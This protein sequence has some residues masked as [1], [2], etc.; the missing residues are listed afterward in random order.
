MKDEHLHFWNR[1]IA[2]AEGLEAAPSKMSRRSLFKLA[3]GLGAGLV[4]GSYLPVRA[5]D[6][7]V[8]FAPN[9][10]IIV[11]PENTVTVIVKH[12]DKGQGAA[13]GL[14]TLVAEEMDAAWSQIQTE[15][16]PSDA[17]RYKNLAFGVQGVGGS[18]GLANSFMQYRQAGAAARQML[19]AAAARMWAVSPADLKVSNG[20]IM[21]GNDK[22]TFGAM[23]NRAGQEEMPAKPAVKTPDKFVYIGRSFPRVDSRAKCTG[24]AKFTLDLAFPDMLIATMLRPPRFGATLIAFDALEAR[25]IAGVKDVVAVDRGIA[26]VADSTWTALKAREAVKAEWNLDAAET[27][28]TSDMHNDYSLLL[29]MPGTPARVDGDVEKA[30]TE[31]SST[32]EA[33][34]EFPYLAHAPMEPMNA[35]VQFDGKRVDVWTGSQ[36]QTIDQGVAAGVFGVKPENVAIHT[37]WAGGSFG[38]RAAADSHYVAE[39]CQIVKALKTPLPVKLVWTRDDDI[40]G[41]YFRPFYM[42]KIKAALDRDGNVS[43]WK[44]RIV[45]QSILEG[46]LFAALMIKNGVD[47]TSVEG[48]KN[49]PYAIPNF[50]LDLHAPKSKVPVLWWRSVG[51]T[52]T[53]HATEHMIDILAREAGKDP[54]EFRLAM[55]KDKPRHSG[56]LKLAA[57]KAGWG[58]PLAP[59]VHRGVGVH[60]SF[61]SYVA[62]VVEV[63]VKED[64]TF[65]IERVVCAVDCGIAVNPDVVKAQMEGGIGYGL[66]AALHGAVTLTNGEVDQSNF[67]DYEVLRISQMPQIEVY[68]VESPEPPTGVGEPGTPVI[69][70]ALANALLSATGVRTVVL[71]MSR[72]SY[73]QQT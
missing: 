24:E 70:P 25:K 7:R 67:H 72:Q 51:S 12:L 10:F 26:I 34:F 18:T 66:G 11:S 39:A 2:D 15:F 16:A 63:A 53:A 8:T 40:K 17:D 35:V 65:K 9:P 64:G 57:E 37:V 20:V 58:S 4:I 3:G 47:E 69:L 48:A 30:F 42:H 28:S 45:G 27:R 1:T 73:K 5:A 62:Q 41:G 61:K 32:I 55:L 13:T 19:V 6:G 50:A 43:A 22:T 54:V 49:L 29:D 44:H 56:V 33:I 68:I 14:A 23:A 36:M 38:R 46:T 21:H 31:A 59:G 60:E 52:H 71:P